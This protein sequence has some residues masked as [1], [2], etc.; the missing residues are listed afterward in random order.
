MSVSITAPEANDYIVAGM[1]ANS[2]NGYLATKGSI[3]Q[4][5]GLTQNSG[6]NSVESDLCDNTTTTATSVTCLS[7]SGS[8]AWAVSALVLC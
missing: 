6:R 8:A 5:G 1:G 4:A 2:Y 3:R 7:I